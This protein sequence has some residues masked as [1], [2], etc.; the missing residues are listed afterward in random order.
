MRGVASKSQGQICAARSWLCLVVPA[1]LTLIV[2]G[3]CVTSQA[4]Q[5]RDID[6]DLFA[7][8][9]NYGYSYWRDA[10][11]SPDAY[12]PVAV[13][14]GEALG[15][16]RLR[17]PQDL[18]VLDNKWIYILDSGNNRVI[19]ANRSWEIESITE[20]F[21]NPETNEADH[22]SGPRGL[23]VTRFGEL[24]VADTENS[25]IVHFS[26]S[27]EVARII[28]PPEMEAEGVIPEGFVYRPEKL[29]VDPAGRI[30]VVVADEYE[31]LLEIDP[32][33]SV[34]G[35]T[36]APRVTP[37]PLD[38][39]WQRLATREQ[40]ERL[41]LFL[42]TR[43]T[44]IDMDERGFKYV[45]AAE[46]ASQPIKRLNGSGQDVLRRTGFWAPQGDIRYPDWW[47][48][49]SR[50]GVS[51]LVDIATQEHE[52]YSVLD[53][54][55]GR[56]FTY[57][58]NGNLLM[59]FGG[60]SDQKGASVDAVAL[61][62]VNEQVL[63]LDREL[64]RITV[65]EPTEY[66]RMIVTAIALYNIGDYER[67]TDVWHGVIELNANYDLAHSSIGWSLLQQEEYR[68]AMDYFRLGNDRL[69]YSKALGFY[70]KEVVDAHFGRALL[71]L[72]S[73]VAAIRAT[74]WLIRRRRFS[75]AVRASETAS[76]AGLREP[77]V[78][79]GMLRSVFDALRYSLHLVVRP[80][81]GFWE[82]KHVGKGNLPAA[83]VLLALV[84][85]TFVFVRQYTGFPFNTRDPNRLNILIEVSSV[86]VPFLLWCGVNWALTTLMEG[87][88]TFREIV[89]ASSYALTPIILV[90]VPATVL[91]NC[92]TVQEGSFYYGLTTIG[93][94]W[95]VLLLFIGMMV[96][97]E[98]YDAFK[99]VATSVLTVAGIVFVLFIGMAFF[100]L[101]DQ[102]VVF[103]DTIYKEIAF[104]L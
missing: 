22:F 14:D 104:R 98:Y 71:V 62:T 89:I 18:F 64:G 16:G 19:I 27:G 87:K 103:V 44:N 69:G 1:V 51:A 9:R 65:Y 56:V 76:S 77:P 8:Y 32:D 20:E 3:P 11:P 25:R 73:V 74:A 15:C 24:Y 53:S 80:F 38:Y 33:G 29:A 30:C 79:V 81:L 58:R 88:G 34:R 102:F 83:M 97:H 68:R 52:M 93:V 92:I 57:D 90:L 42:P 84:S 37:N 21:P 54:R 43:Y 59:I 49:W 67:A 96:T 55:R 75:R 78:V 61:D 7:P 85:A 91:S 13:V 99:A 46:P 47:A 10:V 6:I 66:A 4:G 48:T 50:G 36:G 60:K 101:V 5:M 28:G 100:S 45:T 41:S 72:I 2:V 23:F 95:A 12:V 94:G 70:R 26:P 17:A 39:L 82:L 86:V 35:F 63:V 31:G 40:R